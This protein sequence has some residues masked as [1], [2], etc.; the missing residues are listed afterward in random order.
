MQVMTALSV[1]KEALQRKEAS[2][3]KALAQKA[4]EQGRTIFT[5]P[6]VSQILLPGLS[7]AHAWHQ[8]FSSC[9]SCLIVPTATA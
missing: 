8:D 5:I 7:S 3:P 1:A 2:Q 9:A 4:L 6:K